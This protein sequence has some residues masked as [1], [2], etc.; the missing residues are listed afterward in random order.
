[1]LRGPG[2]R[3][4]AVAGARGLDMLYGEG[5]PNDQ[6]QNHAMAIVYARTLDATKVVVAASLVVEMICICQ[7][8]CED[9]EHAAG[10]ARANA[11][12]LCHSE[13]ETF[14]D[15]AS[16]LAITIVHTRM[17]NAHGIVVATSVACVVHGIQTL[18][19]AIVAAC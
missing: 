5:P 15:Q 17:L 13:K 12:L 2:A 14:N 16:N 6:A 1:M 10:R 11:D 9:P 18:R 7:F 3:C 8:C 19:I 4:G